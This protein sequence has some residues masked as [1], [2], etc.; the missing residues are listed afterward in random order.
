MSTHRTLQIYC[1]MYL[2]VKPFN[3]DTNIIKHDPYFLMSM[4]TLWGK[5]VVKK[6]LSEEI[7]KIL[8]ES[9]K[10]IF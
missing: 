10:E 1:R 4:E 8:K 9:I 7:G 6:A 5:E 2:G 3:T